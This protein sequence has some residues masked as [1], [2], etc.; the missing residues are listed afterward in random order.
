MTTFDK[1]SNLNSVS[2]IFDLGWPWVTLILD[3]SKIN[4]KAF[5]LT[6]FPI[7]DILKFEICISNFRFWVTLSD[8][9]LPRYYI[10]KKLTSISSFWCVIW[11][12]WRCLKFDS[13]EHKLI[14]KFEAIFIKF[15][16]YKIKV[17]YF[18]QELIRRPRL[19]IL[20]VL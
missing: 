16:Y 6:F 19:L 7:L 12:F 9:E 13:I 1:N 15:I 17:S 4:A 20:K 18:T 8:L 11:L 14:K 10:T 2:R 3:F 5:I